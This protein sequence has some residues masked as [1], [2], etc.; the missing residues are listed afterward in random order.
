MNEK[1]NKLNE[2]QKKFLEVLKNN[3]GLVYASCSKFG[4]TAPTYYNWIRDNEEFAQEVH[5][6]KETLIDMAEGTLYEK[7]KQK[8]LTA[9]IFFLKTIGRNRGYIEKYV[10][11]T[12]VK[13]DLQ[14]PELNQETMKL[15]K[16]L[17]NNIS[18]KPKQ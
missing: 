11:E 17:F 2:K 13:Q 1:K 16:Q 10:N 9:T 3:A 18:D 14:A 5:S 8:D 6:I 15:A 12:T 4:I 7:I